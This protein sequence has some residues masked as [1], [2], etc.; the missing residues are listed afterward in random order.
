MPTACTNSTRSIVLTCTCCTCCMYPCFLHTSGWQKLLESC[1]T[2]TVIHALLSGSQPCT[3]LRH[4]H[5]PELDIVQV[6]SFCN[7]IKS[8]LLPWLTGEN[9]SRS[10]S[11][12]WCGIPMAHSSIYMIYYD[13]NIG[14]RNVL[15]SI[16][17]FFFS[18]FFFFFLVE[19]G[20]DS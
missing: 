2:M 5:D 4:V 17:S 19:L 13:Y 10:I 11:I 7:A 8:V 16:D 18:H 3:S 6:V 20:C 9:N 15:T 12:S 1:K 14:Y